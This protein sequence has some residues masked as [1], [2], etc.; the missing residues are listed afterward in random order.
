MT[1]T[2]PVARAHAR[3]RRA[4]AMSLI[5]GM[6]TGLCLCGAAMAETFTLT[7]ALNRAADYDPSRRAGVHH[8]ES[9]QAAVRQ[10]NVKPNPTIGV[11]VENL[12][13]SGSYSLLDRS[14]TTVYYQQTL[15]RGGKRQ[16]RTDLAQIDVDIA[17]LRLARTRLDLFETVEKLWVE[18][19]VADAFVAIA[20]DRLNTAQKAQAEV[21][22]RVT[23]ARDPLFAGTAADT[24]VA[25]AQIALDMA[26]SKAAEA[27]FAVA[28]YWGGDSGFDLDMTGFASTSLPDLLNDPGT[29]LDVRLLERQRDSARARIRLE[30]TRTT[31]DV[32]VKGGVRY[33]GDGGDAAFIVGGSIPLGRN[34]TNRGNIER[35]SA[36]QAA[37]E[38]DI[39]LSRTTALRTRARLIAKLTMT[40]Q[41]I[42][43]IDAETLPPAERTLDLVREGYARGGFRHTDVI[44][45]MKVIDTVKA[46][47][48]DL[49]KTF[50]LDLATLNRLDGRY[51]GL[52]QS[53]IQP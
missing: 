13:G 6:M 51:A 45:A 32:S 24:E 25:Q 1:S 23:A 11:D 21:K 42:T 43:R 35:A 50:H 39:E 30:Q 36:D 3:T 2:D 44:D 47:R 38:A 9:A 10:A 19:Q 37:A 33:F 20:E 49:L 15:E 26:R 4:R 53:D 46:R 27:K 29:S 8:I 28:A 31:Q 22:R 41:E 17:Q 48:I 5:L 14:E 16:A 12:G 7:E 52:A 18:A 34:D 40:A